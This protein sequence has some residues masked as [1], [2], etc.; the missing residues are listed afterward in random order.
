MNQAFPAMALVGLVGCATPASL[1]QKPPLVEY[2]TSKSAKAV[3]ARISKLWSEHSGNIS[4]LLTEDG[5][6]ISLTNYV[7]GV[8]ATVV[9]S[10]KNG[11]TTVKYS[12]RIPSLSPAWM[13]DAVELS[14]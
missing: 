1:A 4:T 10:E 11:E 12:E 2:K 13:K 6:V 7:A 3:A 14:K 9:I 5:Y 8:D